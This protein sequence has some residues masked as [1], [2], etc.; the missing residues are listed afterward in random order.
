[1]FALFCVYW[2]LDIY[3][4][5]AEYHSL[6]SRC[7]GSLNG[8][9]AQVVSWKGADWVD[10]DGLLPQYFT[11][12][13]VEYMIELILIVLGDFVSLWRAYVI[14]G[15]SRWLCKL[16]GCIAVIESEH[17]LKGR[18]RLHW[19]DVQNFTHRSSTRRGFTALA[20][21]IESGVVYLVI[22]TWY[23]IITTFGGSS[24]LLVYSC[25]FYCAP[26]IAMYPT[27]VVAL[28]TSRHSVLE[29]SIDSGILSDVMS[30]H[31]T[32]SLTVPFET[33]TSEGL[34]RGTRL[35]RTLVLDATPVGDG[36][37]A[38]VREAGGF[39]LDGFALC[40]RPSPG[41]ILMPPWSTNVMYLALA[42]QN[43]SSASYVQSHG[44]PAT[45]NL[46]P[47]TSLPASWRALAAL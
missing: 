43:S 12:V 17:V 25:R 8:S 28:V 33:A 34:D 20:I 40:L 42:I 22:L 39:A 11:P 18:I 10:Q 47:G 45:P 26:F 37:R 14:F 44:R 31:F 3:Y 23:G 15:R 19:R 29:R 35:H 5:W 13:Y 38:E 2:A 6:L 24:S 41:R 1:M 4:L 46:F 9:K 30:P 36:A 32:L 27:L 16:L 7:S 21:I